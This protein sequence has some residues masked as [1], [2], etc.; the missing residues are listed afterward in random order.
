MERLR[1]CLL[2]IFSK[3]IVL[4]VISGLII[5]AAESTF[6]QALKTKSDVAG[7]IVKS[8]IVQPFVEQYNIM[9]TARGALDLPEIEGNLLKYI[10]DNKKRL[11]LENFTSKR[12]AEILKDRNRNRFYSSRYQNISFCAYP[13]VH[14]SDKEAGSEVFEK[15]GE[16]FEYALQNTY[17]YLS[18]IYSS[19][20][21]SFDA[22]KAADEAI[23]KI[24]PLLYGNANVM[25]E[26]RAIMLRPYALSNE[27]MQLHHFIQKIQEAEKDLK[28]Y[29][30]Y[31]AAHSGMSEEYLSFARTNKTNS[32]GFKLLVRRTEEIYDFVQAYTNKTRYIAGQLTDAERA[33]SVDEKYPAG[34][35]TKG[36]IK[37]SHYKKIQEIIEASC[38]QGMTPL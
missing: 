13:A 23:D 16:M 9:S 22:V 18:Q 12:C 5:S 35:I 25:E 30:K 15:E 14:W 11:I 32:A 19:A 26:A 28:E 4:A 3:A 27:Y 37:D 31:P 33:V 24:L 29:D 2:I 38:L 34:R 10:K 21:Y 20:G 17:E 1:N 36:S 8:P 6:A 7:N